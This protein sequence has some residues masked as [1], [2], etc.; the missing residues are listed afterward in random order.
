[1]PWQSHGLKSR[2]CNVRLSSFFFLW[3]RSHLTIRWTIYVSLFWMTWGWH[4]NFSRNLM[5]KETRFWPLHVF[6]HPGSD[7]CHCW[8]RGEGAWV[9]LGLFL[10]LSLLFFLPQSGR[11]QKY[12]P[13]ICRLRIAMGHSKKWI[14]SDWEDSTLERDVQCPCWILEG[15]TSSHSSCGLVDGLCSYPLLNM[16]TEIASLPFFKW[17]KMICFYDVPEFSASFPAMAIPFQPENRQLPGSRPKVLLED[18]HTPLQK[19]RQVG[20]A[21]DLHKATPTPRGPRGPPRIRWRRRSP[22]WSSTRLLNC[23]GLV[24]WHEIF[25]RIAT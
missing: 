5:A 25:F 6:I 8:G 13:D 4:P 18:L 17:S 3:R 10:S 22:K 9:F 12:S 7:V 21:Q 24:I 19:L 11:T 16:A 2:N 15:S 1:M 23:W 14:A 20:F